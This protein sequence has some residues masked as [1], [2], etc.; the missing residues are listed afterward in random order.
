MAEK[1]RN[2]KESKNKGEEETNE[3]EKNKQIQ[4]D[5]GRQE[6]KVSYTYRGE[7]SV[8]SRQQKRQ[9]VL[10]QF[11]REAKRR[12]ELTTAAENRMREDFR[13]KQE[14]EEKKLREEENKKRSLLEDA[15]AREL[16][17][18]EKWRAKQQTTWEM[19]ETEEQRQLKQKERERQLNEE[20]E[21]VQRQLSEELQEQIEN[22]CQQQIEEVHRRSKQ[23]REGY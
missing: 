23:I 12:G 8:E 17:C 6:I 13:K 9:G 14:A 2:V 10:E 5:T 18:T 7:G 11:I 15:L 16:Q 3:T 19:E 1:F 22:K 20:F 4:E 21:D